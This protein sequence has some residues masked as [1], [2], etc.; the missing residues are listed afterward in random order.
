MSTITFSPYRNETTDWHVL[1]EAS[2]SRI[3]THLDT[4]NVG[5]ITAFRGGSAEALEINR[6]RNRELQTMIRKKGFGY[7]RLKYQWIENEGT[8]EEIPVIEE[9]FFVIGSDGDDN[10]K[11]KGFLRTTMDTYKQEAA[12][13]KPWDSTTANLMYRN[14]PTTLISIGTFSVNPE[15]IGRMYSQFKDKKFVFHSLSEQRS[16]MSRLAHQKGYRTSR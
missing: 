4:R 7:L 9:S 15:N 5:I 6:A 10:G 3:L 8:P 12:I 16:F 1:D 13:F 11:L 14:D 2:L